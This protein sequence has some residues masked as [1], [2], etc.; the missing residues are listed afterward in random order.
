MSPILLKIPKF[1]E[2]PTEFEFDHFWHNLTSKKSWNQ[3]NI[4]IHHVLA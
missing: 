3:S 4:P 1:F 2:I